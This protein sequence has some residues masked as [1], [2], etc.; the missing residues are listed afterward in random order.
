MIRLN[1]TRLELRVEDIGEFTEVKAEF[2]AFKKAKEEKQK[3]LT[4][5]NNTVKT[6]QEVVQERIGFVPRPRHSSQ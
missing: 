5:S 6:K 3:L 2:D 4:G 1:P